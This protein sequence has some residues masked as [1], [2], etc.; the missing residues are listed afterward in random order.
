[1]VRTLLDPRNDGVRVSHRV[2]REMQS[3]LSRPGNFIR[4]KDD[5]ELL[6]LI[7]LVQ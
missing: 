3:L 1:M 2:D 6:H 7:F 4:A 5:K